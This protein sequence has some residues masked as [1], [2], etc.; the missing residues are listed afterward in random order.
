M[1]I[2]Y[3]RIPCPKYNILYVAPRII[4]ISYFTVLYMCKYENIFFILQLVYVT[5]YIAIL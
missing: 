5:F 3:L 4:K 2:V 1:K